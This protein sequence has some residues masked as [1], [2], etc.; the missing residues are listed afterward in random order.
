[1]IFNH[2]TIE[3]AFVINIEKHG[4]DRGFFARTFCKRE[5][6]E[7]GI[8]MDLCQANIGFSRFRGTLRGLHYQTT[9]HAEAKLVRCLRGAVFDVL[10]DLRPES[11]SYCQW[12]GVELTPENRRML[13]IPKGCAHGYQALQH[14]TEVFY[15]VSDY[16][17]PEHEKG[18][19]WNDAAF[20][21]QWPVTENLTISDKDR[22]WP[23][24]KG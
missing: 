18:L 20:N 10:V 23:D 19:R 1:M 24:F 12:F 3:G 6:A 7:Q 8:H 4:D 21:I 14:N 13:F 11:S 9:P 15:L 22:L 5:F 16:Y 2:T 17:A